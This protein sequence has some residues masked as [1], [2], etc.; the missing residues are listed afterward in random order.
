[1]PSNANAKFL[2]DLQ[3][4]LRDLEARS[5]RRSLSELSG[6]NLCSNDYLGLAE[7]P[8]LRAAVLEGVQAATRVGGTGSRL[9]SGH[10]RIWNDLE[11][12]FAEFVGTEG[13]LY[14]GSGYTANV[15]LL[16]S[17]LKKEDVV[18]SD[19]HNHASLIDGVRLSGARKVIYPHLDLNAL[20]AAL[21][22]SVPDQGRRVIVTETVFSMD[23]DVA[24]VAELLELCERFG[25]AL[26]LD[27][28][29]ATAVHGPT[30]RG[31]AAQAG[32]STR[33]LAATHTCGK[34]LASAGAFVCGSAV[35]KEHLINH[36]RTFIF[37]TAMPP[38]MAAQIGAALNLALGMDAQREQLLERS[39][40]LAASLRR[41]SYDIAGSSTQI[42]PVVIGGNDDALNAAAFL[43][44]EGFAVR[45]IRPPTVAERSARLRFSITTELS[46]QDLQRLEGAM[47]KWAAAHHQ[48]RVMAGRA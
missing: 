46:L 29:H 10:Q 34:A 21:R 23:G 32:G 18:F 47:R 6:I 24:P 48:E 9:L 30:G 36:A 27:E 22:H 38:Y 26:I 19:A 17:V 37:T 14:F 28:A 1:M 31:I 20:E 44:R 25:A 3:A 7:R 41:M 12:Q 45:A 13:A 2:N 35:L 33:V 40:E 16:T 43:Q 42:L 4:G 8:E 5:Q 11:E 15:G 39:R